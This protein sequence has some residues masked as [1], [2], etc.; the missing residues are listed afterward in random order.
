MLIEN[1]IADKN[2]L[3]AKF[4]FKPKTLEY[5]QNNDGLCGLISKVALPENSEIMSVPIKN[6]SLTLLRAYEEAEPLL[7]NL[8]H[9]RFSLPMNFIL[10]CAMYLRCTDETTKDN[11]LLV[12]EYD[13]GSFYRGTPMSGYLSEAMLSIANYNDKN[14]LNEGSKV[15]SLIN[16]LDVDEEVFRALLAHCRSHTWGKF[17]I[18]PVFEW[19]NSSYGDAANV[20]F[21]IEDDHFKYFSTKEIEAGEELTWNYNSSGV[22]P[23]WLYYGYVDKSRPSQAILQFRMDENLKDAYDEFVLKHLGVRKHTLYPRNKI[24]HSRTDFFMID[25]GDVPEHKILGHIPNALDNFRAVRKYFREIVL[26]EQNTVKHEVTVLNLKDDKNLFGWDVE[27]K[28]ISTMRQALYTG[29]NDEKSRIANFEK[30]KIGHHIDMTPLI[31]LRESAN[32]NWSE[33]FVTIEELIDARDEDGIVSILN[34]RFNIN[35]ISITEAIKVLKA[36]SLEKPSVLIF[37]VLTYL[38][39]FFIE[40]YV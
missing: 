1:I 5:R 27:K 36:L 26:S 38:E 15:D 13:V 20:Q 30:T 37:V 3:G 12:P 9:D 10:A 16:Q 22:I 21:L 25:P 39:S 18:I 29:L 4:N 40:I 23:T 2:S 7:K 35:T 14:A 28:V 11:D 6:G 19:M 17:G 31:D 24:D 8:G 33:V 34:E 32:K